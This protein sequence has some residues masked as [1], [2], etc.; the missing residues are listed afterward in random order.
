[1]APTKRQRSTKEEGT[2][3]Q[4]LSR[5]QQSSRTST[6]ARAKGNNPHP[7]GLPNPD[8]V[9]RYTFLN[10][11]IVVATHYYEEELLGRLGLPDDIQ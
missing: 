9:A 10:E 3:S 2:S 4:A 6:S 8:H 11:R 5:R 7:L 1:M